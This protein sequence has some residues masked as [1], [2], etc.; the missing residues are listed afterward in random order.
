MQ[1]VGHHKHLQSPQMRWGGGKFLCIYSNN[2][3]SSILG[4][5]HIY[6]AWGPAQVSPGPE[7][8]PFWPKVKAFRERSNENGNLGLTFW[9]ISQYLFLLV[10]TF[11]GN[12]TSEIFHDKLLCS[13]ALSLKR[14]VQE[15]LKVYP[16]FCHHQKLGNFHLEGNAFRFQMRWK[17]PW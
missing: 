13:Y 17:A 1:P 4:G 7:N 6:S 15:H 11:F 9:Q 10:N 2:P 8:I 3:T 5:P 12:L 16:N 14:K